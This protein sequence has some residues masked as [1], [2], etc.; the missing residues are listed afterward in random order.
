MRMRR[1]M[2]AAITMAALGACDVQAGHLTLSA[3]LRLAA[4]ESGMVQRSKCE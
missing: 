4:S 3:P 1:R 2:V